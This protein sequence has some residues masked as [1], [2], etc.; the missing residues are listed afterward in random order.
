[1]NWGAST[2]AWIAILG[3]MAGFQT[4]RG[5]YVDGL[6]FF[7]LTAMLIIDQATAGRL[8]VLKRHISVPRFVIFGITGVLGALLV[9]S[10]RRSWVDLLTLISI[11]LTVLIVA[12]QP[13]PAH[14]TRNPKSYR[15]S[16]YIWSI[17]AVGMSLW[18]VVAFVL[19]VTVGLGTDNF[20]TVS[21][22]LDPFVSN[23]AGRTIFVALWLAAGLGLLRLWSK[24]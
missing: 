16:I 1:M 24:R 14:T 2:I 23:L 5:A 4:W 3:I 22:I 12:W 6:L 13:A 8:M 21:V 7:A 15:R 11:G 9:M 19:S 17:L 18:E 20:P 10:P